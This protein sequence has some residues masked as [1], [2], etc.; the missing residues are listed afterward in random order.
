MTEQHV[1][2]IALALV[3]N[4]L[5]TLGLLSR[6]KRGIGN[7]GFESLLILIIYIIACGVM[8]TF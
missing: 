6:E 5:L 4:G 7:I 2:I 8:F 3:L 1:F